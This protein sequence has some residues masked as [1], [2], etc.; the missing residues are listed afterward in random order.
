[1]EDKEAKRRQVQK[2]TQWVDDGVDNIKSMDQIYV[3][4]QH[5]EVIIEEAIKS[6]SKIKAMPVGNYPRGGKESKVT[7]ANK[8][9]SGRKLT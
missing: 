6:N 5:S 4:R 8:G 7:A 1:M 3:E 2:M 9:F